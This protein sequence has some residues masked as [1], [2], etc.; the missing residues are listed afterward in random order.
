M[1]RTNNGRRPSFFWQGLMILLPVAVLAVVGLFSLRQD[2][3]A[4]EQ[5]ARKKAAEN[6]Q[7][8]ARAMSTTAADQLREYA[9]LQY[10]W[11]EELRAAIPDSMERNPKQGLAAFPGQDLKTRI[12]QWE[13]SYPGLHLD[14]QIGSF[15]GVSEQGTLRFIGI[16]SDRGTAI[17]PKDFDPVPVPSPWFL[18]FSP[19]QRQAWQALRQSQSRDGVAEAGTS[20]W[21]DFLGTNPSEES[22]RAAMNYARLNRPQGDEESYN[23]LT[24][25][26]V[27]FSDLAFLKAIDR[28]A[29]TSWATP[30]LDQLSMKVMFEPSFLTSAFLEKAK[31][32]PP[33]DPSMLDTLC[34]IQKVWDIDSAAR[35]RLLAFRHHPELLSGNRAAEAPAGDGLA[36]P[37]DATS[38]VNGVPLPATGFWFVPLDVVQAIFARGIAREPFSGTR[39]CHAGHLR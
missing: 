24:E 33:S 4:A 39:L 36:F 25:S 17:S 18:E 22:R 28:A 12:V 1:D 6:V 26:G 34:L 8:L 30:L 11:I 19:I 35:Q 38:T 21:Q 20:A 32:H 2:E 27:P 23:G 16:V 7:I 29:N 5:A 13:N 14:Q 10:D 37:F 15:A 31:E 9:I 3:Q